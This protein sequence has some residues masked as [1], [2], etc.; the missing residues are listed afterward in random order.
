M[1]CQ[2]AQEYET[3]LKDKKT[4]PPPKPN[5]SLSWRKSTKSYILNGEPVLESLSH[6]TQQVITDIINSSNNQTSC[7]IYK[8]HPNRNTHSQSSGMQQQEKV[9]DE[10]PSPIFITRQRA[11]NKVVGKAESDC[12]VPTPLI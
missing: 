10:F 6:A 7:P 2:K 3:M 4:T 9:L 8:P 1:S 5:V 12:N 11:L